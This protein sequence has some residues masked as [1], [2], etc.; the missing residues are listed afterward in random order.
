MFRQT[1]YLKSRI[2]EKTVSPAPIPDD[3]VF[4]SLNKKVYDV[5]QAV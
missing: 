1:D 5:L 4:L 2:K 3:T